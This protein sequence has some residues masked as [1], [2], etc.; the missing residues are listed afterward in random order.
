MAAGA[1]LLHDKL[2]GRIDLLLS[3]KSTL[4][5]ILAEASS[6]SPT[7]QDPWDRVRELFLIPRDRIYLNVG[8]LGAQPRSVVHAVIDSTRKVAES[9]PAGVK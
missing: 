4:S 8:T 3:Q 6:T 1:P 2:G 7:T 5:P 9:L